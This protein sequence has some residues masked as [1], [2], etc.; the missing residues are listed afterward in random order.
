[1]ISFVLLIFLL[2]KIFVNLFFGANLLESV[3]PNRTIIGT[4]AK[5]IMCII[6]LSIDTAISNLDDSAVTRAGQAN[7]EFNSGNIADG[8]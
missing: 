7:L 1:M 4:F 5:D 6:P 3:G 8:T 2:S